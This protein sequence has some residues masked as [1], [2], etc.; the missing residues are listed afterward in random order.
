VIKASLRVGQ[1][2]GKPVSPPAHRNEKIIK[3][4]TVMPSG[5]EDRV[6]QLCA[7]AIAAKSEPELRSILPQLRQAI[8]DHIRYCRALAV[9]VIPEA[10]GGDSKAAD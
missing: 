2:T 8:R 10:F 9:E 7:Q 6:H 3:G 5:L 1:S 4:V